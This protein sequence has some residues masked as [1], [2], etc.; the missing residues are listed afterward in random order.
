MESL[1]QTQMGGEDVVLTSLRHQQETQ[2]AF[3][4]LENLQNL[5]K[6]QQPY[7]LWAEEL[8]E[9]ALAIGRVRGRDL[10]TA[11]FEDIFSKFCIG[12]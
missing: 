9:A 11:A 3:Q 5:M 2:K 8:R 4:A 12:K 7:D 1:I 10:P 6:T